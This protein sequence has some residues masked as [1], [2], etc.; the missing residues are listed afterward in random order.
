MAIGGVVFNFVAK[1]ADATRDIKKLDG[2]LGGL[3]G[4]AKK[5]GSGIGSVLSGVGK[6]IPFVGAAVVGAAAGFAA[7][8]KSAIDD[9]TAA[10]KLAGSLKKSTKATNAQVDAA[11]D[12]I[13]QMQFATGIADD[14][15]RPALERAARSTK[16]MGAAQKLVKL[17]MDISARTGKPLAT[18]IRALTKANDGNIKALKGIG[19]T[20]GDN[21]AN[22]S[23]YAIEQGKLLRLQNDASVAYRES[24]ASSKDYQTKLAK[25][26]DQ[27]KKV[28]DLAAAGIDW[29]KELG[30]EFGGAAAKAGATLGG[31]WERIK[32]IFGEIGEAIG[33][34]ALPP[35]QLFA[36]WFADPKNIGKVQGWI[37]KVAEWSTAVGE[38]IVTKLQDFY[39][40][41]QSP[42]GQKAVD[43]FI[44]DLK[45]I[46]GAIQSVID[47]FETLKGWWDWY[48]GANQKGRAEN[49]KDFFNPQGG[50]TAGVPRPGWQHNAGAAGYS[51]GG[52]VVNVYNPKPEKA[53]TSVAAAL[54]VTRP[55]TVSI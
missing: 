14:Q 25:V 38:K 26:A 27:Q 55:N 6:S 51:G 28:N 36:D 12:W 32:I 13:N 42:E 48:T 37:D 53:S 45:A 1:T 47:L 35:L 11:E 30:D 2:V 29:Q 15:L 10:D 46:G 40:W 21:A 39:R 44:G 3:G 54:R 20:L 34:A 17:A 5:A 9:A 19:I 16:D 7:M 24:G 4:T 31:T 50:G 52:T 23:E 41:L 22:A 43:G 8:A 49:P 18:V 33:S